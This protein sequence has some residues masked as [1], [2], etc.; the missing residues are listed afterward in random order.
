MAIR[1]LGISSR[2]QQT[3]SPRAK[4]IPPAWTCMVHYKSLLFWWLTHCIQI[5]RWCLE[6]NHWKNI[7]L[8]WWCI[9][10]GARARARAR[11][12]HFDLLLNFALIIDWWIVI[13]IGSIAEEVEKN[14]QKKKKVQKS[15]FIFWTQYLD[16]K[17]IFYNNLESKINFSKHRF[18]K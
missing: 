8:I 4:N 2:F 18:H 6:F 11:L 3:S 12:A 13:L 10:T 17:Y 14:N 16:T 5:Y 9:G 7:L 15:W 1:C